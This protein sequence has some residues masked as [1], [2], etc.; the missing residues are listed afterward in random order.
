MLRDRLR[1][2]RSRCLKGCRKSGVIFAHRRGRQA[3]HDTFTHAIVV[4]LHMIGEARS[5]AAQKMLGAQQ[6]ERMLDVRARRCRRQ[7]RPKL[8]RLAGHRHDRK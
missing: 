4:R 7:Q 8:E 6:G 3:I 5:R 1:I 2:R